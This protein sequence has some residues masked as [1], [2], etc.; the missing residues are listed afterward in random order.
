[1]VLG[2]LASVAF[3]AG[4]DDLEPTLTFYRELLGV[5]EVGRDDDHVFLSG[6]MTA[7][8]DVAFGPWPVGLHHF[9]FYVGGD[10]DL[11]VAGERLAAT[12][13]VT[14]VDVAG[15]PGLRRALQFPLPSGHLVRLVVATDPI[16]FQ[17]VPTVDQRHVTGVGPTPLEHI[18]IQCV[19]IQQ[20]SEF[21]VEHLGFAITEASRQRDEPWFASFI[22]TRDLHHDLGI[23]RA[24]ESRLDHFG[25][26]VESA[27]SLMR[28][29]DLARGLGYF[30]ACS[31]GRHIAGNNLFLYIRDPLGT[32]V[33]V[34]TP[35]SPIDVAA[36]TRMFEAD[37]LAEWRGTFDAWRD[38]IPSDARAGSPISPAAIAEASDAA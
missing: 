35:M 25:F 3:G 29:A 22:R 14:E 17:P 1:M 38:G 7:D 13:N 12:V 6:G 27:D 36:P 18:S 20:T 34:G 5:A 15:H 2:R 32:L 11:E 33:E 23:F 10:A 28:F 8:Y 21:L 19:D 4:D 37:T 26:T 9:S 30:L 24:K 31:P 16:V